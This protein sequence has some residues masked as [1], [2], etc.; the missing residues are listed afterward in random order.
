MPDGP[1]G[2]VL[3][4]PGPHPGDGEGPVTGL[5]QKADQLTIKVRLGGPLGRDWR[6]E[7]QGGVGRHPPPLSCTDPK[8]QGILGRFLVSHCPHAAQRL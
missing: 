6:A 7:G 8:I 1:H 3:F 4:E 2:D 5:V